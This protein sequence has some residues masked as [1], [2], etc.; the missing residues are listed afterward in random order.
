[1]A[2]RS[3]TTGERKDCSS[4]DAATTMR[5][6]PAQDGRR[7]ET[8]GHAFLRCSECEG[9]RSASPGVRWT[10]SGWVLD[11]RCPDCGTTAARGAE[12][13][14]VARWSEDI[15]PWFADGGKGSR[16]KG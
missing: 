15:G 3:V 14:E 6:T 7:W 8:H 16:R 4:M 13:E 11:W 9:A 12:E 5:D 10:D 2:H 1:M